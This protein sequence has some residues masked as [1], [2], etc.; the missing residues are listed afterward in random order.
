MISLLIGGIGFFL[1]G[2]LLMTDGLKAAAGDALRRL[3]LRF[4]GGTFAA[5][6]SGAALTAMVQSSTAT[7][8]A[9]IGFVSAGLLTF[10]QSI[11][12]IM[13]ANVG[14]TSTGWIV[15]LVGLKLNVS[16]IALPLVGLGALARLV[17]RGRSAA[18]G[19]AIAGF[20]LIFVG[21]D[22][23][24]E[25]M[26]GL[27][28]RIDLAQFSD[29]SFGV[30]IVLLL[31]GA[32]MTVVMQSSSAAMATTL[33]AIHSGTIGLEQGAALV[34][35]QN[36][37]TTVKAAVAAIGASIPARRTAAAHIAFNLVTGA[38]AFI[39]LSPFL[40]LLRLFTA[41]TNDPATALAIFHTAFNLLGLFLF[42]PWI[43][44]FGR[45]IEEMIGE[46]EKSLTRNLSP[47]LATVPAVALEAAHQVTVEIF[48]EQLR[49]I[50]GVFER[51]RLAHRS[52]DELERAIGDTRQFLSRASAGEE[53]QREL[54]RRLSLIHALDHLQSVTNSVH[55]GITLPPHL[56]WEPALTFREAVRRTVSPVEESLI[57]PAPL[58]DAAAEIFRL[59]TERRHEVLERIARGML[60]SEEAEIE[61]ELLRWLDRVSYH[62]W[63]AAHHLSRLV[64][65]RQDEPPA[66]P[67][68]RMDSEH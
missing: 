25:G 67:R 32:L 18:A 42:L 9:T 20:G 6:A 54:N 22:L 36:V 61:L 7:T 53:G 49:L 30:R 41:E 58:R 50:L 40:Y 13:G 12:V 44:R 39:L 4:T 28:A 8:F 23:L 3:L 15:S 34:I 62:L 37:G 52:P 29:D 48:R 1:L 46:G 64:D 66:P 10:T 56:D 59:R 33:A 55:A 35:G 63:R 68:E 57:D 27:A 14:T 38:V 26:G 5:V 31:I 2:M 45:M 47:S 60:R 16:V 51:L 21:I 65:H 19:T 11:G 24:Q 43:G 17:G